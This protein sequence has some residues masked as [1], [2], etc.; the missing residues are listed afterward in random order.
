MQALNNVV[1]IDEYKAKIVEA[2]ALPHY[3]KLL[4][5]EKDESLQKEATHGLWSLTFKCRKDVKKEPKCRD[6]RYLFIIAL[7]F[8]SLQ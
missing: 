6:G 7:N 8:L 4:S 2:G 1:A 3:V 5:P